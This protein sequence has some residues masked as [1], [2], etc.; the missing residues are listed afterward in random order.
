MWRQ[1]RDRGLDRGPGLGYANIHSN[2]WSNLTPQPSPAPSMCGCSE[3]GRY[4]DAA[5]GCENVH[6]QRECTDL[7]CSVGAS[8]GNRW[9][10]L[11]PG[12]HKCAP[13][14]S[15]LGMGLFA[16]SRLRRNSLLGQYV[17]V[18][19]DENPS[20]E[21]NYVAQLERDTLWIDSKHRGNLTRFINHSCAPN[22]YLKRR[23]IG[24]LPTLWIFVGERDIPAGTEVTM[25][26]GERADFFFT[27]WI[28]RCGSPNCQYQ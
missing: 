22:T 13:M 12:L 2:D 26:Y 16:T 4:C 28:C 6:A 8:C 20:A 27:N 18:V 23:F 25:N 15:Q 7:N 3:L 11:E 10:P 19:C 14:P 9:L 1:I 5:I 24:G 21:S 17:G